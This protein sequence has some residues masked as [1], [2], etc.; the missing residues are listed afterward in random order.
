MR[1]STSATP[2]FCEYGL[3]H[4]LTDVPREDLGSSGFKKAQAAWGSPDKF[5]DGFHVG[6][7]SVRRPV[8]PGKFGKLGYSR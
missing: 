6:L 3:M 4:G 5:R 2:C 1:R 8:N 7:C